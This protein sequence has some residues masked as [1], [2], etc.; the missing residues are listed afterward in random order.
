MTQQDGQD[1]IEVQEAAESLGINRKTLE[2][3]AQ[4]RGIQRY[5]RGLRNQVFFKKEDI[6]ALRDWL[7]TIKPDTTE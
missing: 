4:K 7:Y 1:F 5:Q 6:E 2:R 3:H